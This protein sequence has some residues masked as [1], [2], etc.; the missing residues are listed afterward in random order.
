MGLQ[1]S[2]RL[3]GPLSSPFLLMTSM[4]LS[5]WPAWSK[6]YLLQD[7]TVSPSN[8]RLVEVD[9]LC[10]LG[11]IGPLDDPGSS[12]LVLL[13]LLLVALSALFSGSETAIFSLNAVRVRQL[14]DRGVNKA[15]TVSHLLSD[16]HGLLTTILVGNTIVN[17]WLTSLI[18]SLALAIWGATR[19][20]EFAEI[21]ATAIT[22]FL[23]L[24]FGEVTPKA[25]AAHDPEGFSLRVSGPIAFFRRLLAP[26]VTV[27][28][29]FTEWFVG[30]LG[31]ADTTPTVSVTEE[32]IKTAATIGQEEGALEEDE[33]AMIHGI[34]ASGD[35]PVARAMIPRARMVAVEAQDPMD[36]VLRMMI[37]TGY[38]RLPVYDRDPNKIVG[39]IYAKDLFIQLRRQGRGLRA[40]NLLRPAHF[41][42][43]TRKVR[44]LLAEM[45]EKGVHLAIVLGT[46]D[47]VVGLVTLEDLLEEVVGEI[48]DEFDRVDGAKAVDGL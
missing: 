7:L 17:I 22:T 31:G 23:L 25:F 33:R 15:R 3:V 14:L 19:G 10:L 8:R 18:T 48:D 26:V 44:Q 20:R 40:V 47:R 45:Q 42:R 37:S 6:D 29:L 27:V 24:A 46:D 43:A 21:A 9:T 38:S 32:I 5:K 36:K 2:S 13:S 16:A 1:S 28:D 30:R 41:V 4:I 12:Y 39:I 34:F 35:T 11:V